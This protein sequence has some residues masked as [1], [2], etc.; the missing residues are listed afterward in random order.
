M[1]KIKY[2]L[3]IC[4]IVQ[5]GL[6]FAQ[7]GNLKGTVKDSSGKA[8]VYANIVIQNTNFVTQSNEEGNYQ[9]V[10]I[11]VGTYSVLLS[12]TGSKAISKKVNIK[13]NQL[14]ELDFSVSEK[15]NFLNEVVIN[16]VQ[17]ITG[18]GHLAEV[19]D[20]VIY[21]GKKNEV[22]ILD[23]LNAN[24]A[25]NNPRQI[26]G[27]VPGSN[28]SETEGGGFPS[29]GI[30]FRGL[31]PTQSIETNTRQNGYNITGDIY[32]YPESYYLPPLE[33][34]ERIEITRGASALEF[35]P[36][37][38]GVVNYIVKSAPTDKPFQFTTEETGGSYG[39]MNSFNSIGGTYKKISY[40]AFVEG[41]Y[42]SGWRPNSDF[43][44]V[45]GF[46]RLE[47]KANN[48]FKIGLE[49]SFLRNQLH[50]PGGLDDAE[51]NQNPD[52]SFRTR[53]WLTTPW[54]IVALTADYSINDH[55]TLFLKSV[56][57]FSSRSIVWRNEDGGPAS[58]DTINP[59]TLTYQPR[60]VL[61]EYF[62]NSTTELRLVNKYNIGKVHSVMDAGIRFFYGSMNRE[63]GGKGNTASNFDFADSASF[64]PKKIN[65]S[66]TNIAPYIENTFHFGNRLSITPGARLEYL[67]SKASGYVTN[68]QDS[69][70]NINENKVRYLFLSGLGIQFK[71][72]FTTNIYA[73]LSQAYTPI[74]YSFLYPLGLD[75]NAKINPN[76]KDISGYNADLGWRGSIKNFFSFDVS[77]FYMAYNNAI[78]FEDLKD[79]NGNM[80]SY[81]T[82]VADAVH[83]GVESYV[84]LNLVKLFAPESKIGSFSFFNSFAYDNATYI[85]GLYKGNQC[86]YAPPTIERIGWTYA[87][88]SFSTTFLISNTAKQFTDANNTVYS[89]TAL[90]GIIPEFTVMDWSNTIKIKNYNIKFGINNLANEKYFTIRTVE[91]P[92][93]GIIPSMGRSVYVGFGA[94][95]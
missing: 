95:F 88:K 10:K 75:T 94:T 85:N 19:H 3:I 25:Q 15:I 29:N 64:Y 73:N 31:N 66:S 84:E 26:L 40:Y 22:L 69:I 32:G 37:F 27:R 49:Y 54:N 11:P 41:E 36:Q 48:K 68:N 52:Q 72:S 46:G 42:S 56:Q 78:A 8:I 33:A 28:Y 55:T 57:N 38:G 17:S 74:E 1:N 50:M 44:Q 51:F 35:G 90:F 65:F 63:E 86:E 7:T 45:T 61:H 80:Y 92:G 62:R 60:E 81:E 34:I 20:G 83:L 76:L 93:P 39:L 2:V 6:C 82:N 67:Q 5:A 87:L 71:T 4:L 16:G 59:A 21:S 14:S 23:S 9:I 58:M 53:N 79:A 70:I 47:Y 18:M 89:P 24:T 77:G 12:I 91:Y 43:E 13:E 30:G